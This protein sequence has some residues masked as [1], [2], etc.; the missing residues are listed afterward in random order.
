M[1][2]VLL[3][4]GDVVRF[5][6]SQEESIRYGALFLRYIT[7]FYLLTC[8]TQVYASALRGAGNTRATMIIMLC[9]FVFFRQI[10]LFV[11]SRIC[12]EIIPIAMGYPAGWLLCSLACAIY[13]YNAKLTK[14]RL[15]EDK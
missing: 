4:S 1:I 3:F 7:P 10:Y 15:V 12:N 9:S 14:T 11:M 6:T 8:F 2:P 13:F 5:F